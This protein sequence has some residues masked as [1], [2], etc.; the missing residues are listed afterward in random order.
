MWESIP[1]NSSARIT[2]NEKKSWRQL[3]VN[4][5]ATVDILEYT[6]FEWSVH[7]NDYSVY[8]NYPE[9]D[10]TL[11]KISGNYLV[12]N[13]DPPRDRYDR[14]VLVSDHYDIDPNNRS[15]CLKFFYYA[16][17]S[18]IFYPDADSRDT[19]PFTRLEIFQSESYDSI[20]KSDKL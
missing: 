16:F 13:T 2:K 9:Y 10:H 11:N 4:S 17:K 20:K 6:D 19:T 18:L 1:K 5:T 14:A 8:P 15:L 12:F 3:A 7:S